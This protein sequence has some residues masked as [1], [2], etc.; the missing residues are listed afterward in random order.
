MG[1][2]KKRGRYARALTLTVSGAMLVTAGLLA[3]AAYSRERA[4]ERALLQTQAAAQDAA[5][6]LIALP[7]SEPQ[8]IEPAPEAD[9]VSAAEL[10]IAP[11]CQMI[12]TTN[13]TLC[14]HTRE[15][16]R[17]D[18]ALI[19]LTEPEVRAATPEWAIEAFSRVGL[20]FSRDVEAYCPDHVV[21]KSVPDGLGVF[22]TDPQTL[23]L[24]QI[25]QFKLDTSFL[26]EE[27]RLQLELGMSFADLAEIEGYVESLES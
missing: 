11:T 8:G 15:E 1:T 26:N 2:N 22:R 6:E 5:P 18:R 27:T 21:L 9:P 24:Q 4:R 17:Q 14:G 20:H 13:F 3:G 23:E 12:W 19:G 7:S 10:I 25:M 16:T